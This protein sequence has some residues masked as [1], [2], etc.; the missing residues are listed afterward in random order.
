MATSRPLELCLVLQV[1]G[2]QQTVLGY[3]LQFFAVLT[4]FIWLAIR[5]RS[6]K[7]ES[8]FLSNSRVLEN[9]V[10]LLLSQAMNKIQ[11]YLTHPSN[12]LL[13]K[14]SSAAMN[15]VLSSPGQEYPLRHRVLCY[16]RALETGGERVCAMKLRYRH[17]RW[18][19][20]HSEQKGKEWI[21]QIFK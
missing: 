17:L 21:R 14:A 5:Q 8:V 3:C 4:L 9:H 15:L 1:T 7:M 12:V 20:N 13:L 16:E 18:R 11:G 6:A 19:Y 2:F 10:Q